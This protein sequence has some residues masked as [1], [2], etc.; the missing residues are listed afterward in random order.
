MSTT[1]EIMK[2]ISDNEEFLVKLYADTGHTNLGDYFIN[3]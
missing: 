2:F 1:E 3:Y